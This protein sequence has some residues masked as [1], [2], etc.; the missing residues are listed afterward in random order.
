[1]R[2]QARDLRWPFVDSEQRSRG[3]G[4]SIRPGVRALQLALAACWLLD[5]L[6]QYQ[7]FMFGRGFARMLA[8][9]SRGN[10]AVIAGPAAWSVHLTAHHP[11]LA[12]AAFATLQLLLALGIAWRPTV[13][14]ALAASVAWSLAVWWLG[15]GFGGVLTPA[16]SPVTGAPG[17]AVLYA[18]LAVLLWPRGEVAGRRGELAGERGK[19]G[20][21]AGRRGGRGEFAAPFAAA[22][23]VGAAAARVV[24]V[25]LWGSL[26]WFSL[27]NAP[28][29]GLRLLAG[30]VGA[31]LLAAGCCVIAAGILLPARA[32]RWVLAAA[33]V[34]ALALWAAGQG[35]GDMLTGMGT[36]PG[37]GP[38]LAL[39][40]VAY[41]PRLP[42]TTPA[43]GTAHVPAT[44]APL[45]ATPAP[46]TSLLLGATSA[47]GTAR[48]PAT[49]SPPGT[50]PAAGA[51]SS[52]GATPAP[53][54]G[55]IP[56][57]S[58]PSG[59]VAPAGAA[60]SPGAA[61]LSAGR[62][63]AG[64]PPPRGD[65]VVMQVLMGAATG[66]MLAP[67]LD[68]VP[69]LCWQ[70]LAAAGIAWFTWHFLRHAGDGRA[71][72]DLSHVLGCGAM[73]FMLLAPGGAHGAMTGAAMAAAG[74]P[75]AALSVGALMF[76]LAML[77]TAVLTAD[78]LTAQP[79]GGA[80]AARVLPLRMSACCQIVMTILMAHLLIQML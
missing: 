13:R 1:V 8:D 61:V 24:W 9:A 57:T 77:V 20:E 56:G 49:S 46:G 28:A 12:N 44:S 55:R 72:Y 53:A 40:A 29:A 48:A 4:I 70:A 67:R 65:V 63:R 60:L 59:A 43:P 25:A 74:G 5:A 45:S 33:A 23:A 7:P 47:R 75:R 19:R 14:P 76:A 39:L 69:P 26:A 79:A 66:A 34:L 21:L 10:P 31:A 37:T 16:A 52:P 3:R 38:L 42:R 68:P 15:E 35:F 78:Q 50:A 51:A 30:G 64:L 58:S 36:D 32:V 27:S 73:L 54:I 18:L 2:R 6:L 22:A 11:V 41:W 71:G 62:A 80:A 17:A